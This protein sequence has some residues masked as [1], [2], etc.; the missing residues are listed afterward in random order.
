MGRCHQFGNIRQDA[1]SWSSKIE[2]L[3]YTGLLQIEM[4]LQKMEFCP[5]LTS[6]I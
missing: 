1:R 3:K 5:F 4:V 2:E 6:M